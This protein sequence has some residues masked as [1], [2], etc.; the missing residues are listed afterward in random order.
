MPEKS[1]HD[2]GPLQR[3]IMEAVWESQ[4]ATVHQIRDRLADKKELAYTTVLS[5][6]QKLEKTGWLR[7][8]AEGKTY[9]YLPARTRAQGSFDSLHKFINHVFGGSPMA[10]FQNLLSHEKLTDEELVTLRKM[11]DQRRKEK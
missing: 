5:A 9:I 8:R 7:H 10:V 1:I 6:M 11:I 4:Q 2:L 3:E